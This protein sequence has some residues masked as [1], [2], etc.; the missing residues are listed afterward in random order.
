M[1]I[2]FEITTE[3]SEQFEL[4]STLSSAIEAKI[5]PPFTVCDLKKFEAIGE[6]KYIYI[7]M[8]K[9]LSDNSMTN[10]FIRSPVKVI[11]G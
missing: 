7:S 9:Q 3:E 4:K 6:S 2:T 5:I 1:L 8:S 11:H 10:P